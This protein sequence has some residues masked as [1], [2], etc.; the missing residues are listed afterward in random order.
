MAAYMASTAPSLFSAVVLFA[1][2]LPHAGLSKNKAELPPTLVMPPMLVVQMPRDPVTTAGLNEPIFEQLRS[3]GCVLRVY[4][5]QEQPLTVENIRSRTRQ[6]EPELVERMVAHLMQE[7]L[8]DERNFLNG[9]IRA[10]FRNW[11]QLFAGWILETGQSDPLRSFLSFLQIIVSANGQH[12]LSNQFHVDVVEFLL[13][14]SH[15][16]SRT[17]R[18][19]ELCQEF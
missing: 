17:S 7:G 3:K 13:R 5:G 1:P 9:D 4:T 6:I 19:T 8:L 14:Y 16:T 12:S 10:S 2:E 15:D 11:G 18:G